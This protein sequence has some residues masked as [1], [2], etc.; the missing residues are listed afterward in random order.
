VT[1]EATVG[2]GALPGETL[3]SVALRIDA[4]SAGRLQARLRR[5]DPCV[6][7]RVEDGAVIVDLRTVTPQQDKALVGALRAAVETDRA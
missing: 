4:D 2:G 3:P 1:T 5:E 6:V 7:A